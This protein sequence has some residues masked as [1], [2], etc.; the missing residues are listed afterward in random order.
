MTSPDVPERLGARRATGQCAL[1]LESSGSITTR[2]MWL[3]PLERLGQPEDIAFVR[4]LA[5]GDF[6]SHRDRRAFVRSLLDGSTGV[7]SGGR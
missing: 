6:S 2:K 1:A 4:R 7:T 5:S 3:A